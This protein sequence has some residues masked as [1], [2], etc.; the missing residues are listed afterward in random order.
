MRIGR[1]SVKRGEGA[2]AVMRGGIQMFL[3]SLHRA[4]GVE[5]GFRNGSFWA[6]TTVCDDARYCTPSG[7]GEREKKALLRPGEDQ[8]N[9]CA[10]VRYGKNLSQL[11]ISSVLPPHEGSLIDRRDVMEPYVLHGASVYDAVQFHV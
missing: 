8:M 10:E 3:A 6:G 9:H 1:V 11:G 5:E 4:E 7:D 2:G